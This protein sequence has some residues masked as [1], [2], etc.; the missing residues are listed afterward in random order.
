M[1]R[2]NTIYTALGFLVNVIAAGFAIATSAP[3]WAIS[4]LSACAGLQLGLVWSR[5]I[6]NAWSDTL[7]DYRAYVEGR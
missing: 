4:L 6:L 7:R 2:K 3:V 5:I 1:P